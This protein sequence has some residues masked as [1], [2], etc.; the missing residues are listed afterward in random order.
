[1][2][3]KNFPSENTCHFL[4]QLSRD[5]LSVQRAS[6]SLLCKK[7]LCL[8]SR[9]AHEKKILH[10]IWNVNKPS[11]FKFSLCLEAIFI[12]LKIILLKIHIFTALTLE[13]I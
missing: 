2:A 9:K 1:M 5:P 6:K 4:T 13:A 3:K 10:K 12:K 7:C 11:N 8:S